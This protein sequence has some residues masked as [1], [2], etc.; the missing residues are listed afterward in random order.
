MLLLSKTI[1]EYLIENESSTTELFCVGVCQMRFPLIKS[2]AFTS[3]SELINTTF[4]SSK[5]KETFF[6]DLI[7]VLSLIYFH[8]I[9]PFFYR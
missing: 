7:K 8:M 3:P 9:L 4:L 6:V 1:F 5:I 2:R